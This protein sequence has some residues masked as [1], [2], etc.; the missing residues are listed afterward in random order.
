MCSAYYSTGIRRAALDIDFVILASVTDLFLA[1]GLHL[2]KYT[3][4]AQNR[5]CHVK[6]TEGQHGYRYNFEEQGSSL[7]LDSWDFR[8]RLCQCCVGFFYS[9][10]TDERVQKAAINPAF[11]EWYVSCH[12]L[13]LQFR[14]NKKNAKE[15]NVKSQDVLYKN[16]TVNRERD[17]LS[18]NLEYGNDYGNGANYGKYLV[19]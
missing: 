16:T 17:A 13:K 2:V 11:E 5:H 12:R 6:N 15:E 7:L 4:Q 3:M 8:V 18:Q 9:N 1:P 19:P 14:T 10:Y